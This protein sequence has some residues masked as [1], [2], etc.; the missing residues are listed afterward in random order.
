MHHGLM[1]IMEVNQNKDQFRYDLYVDA[2]HGDDDSGKSTSG[3][4]AGYFTET[5]LACVDWAS[6]LQTAAAYSTPEAE[7]VAMATAMKR[8]GM[9]QQDLLEKMNNEKTVKLVVHVDNEAAEA[10]VKQ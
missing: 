9:P 6:K 7:Y 4:C 5:S 2:D 1:L 3:W 10:R 8:S